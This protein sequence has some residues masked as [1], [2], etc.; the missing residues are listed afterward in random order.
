MNENK[1]LKMEIASL[2]RLS[3]IGE[4]AVNKIQMR[5]PENHPVVFQITEPRSGREEGLLALGSSPK[6]RSAVDRVKQVL[7]PSAEA[8]PFLGE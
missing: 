7:L 4:I 3:R 8:G 1:S 5:Y 6:V 2:S